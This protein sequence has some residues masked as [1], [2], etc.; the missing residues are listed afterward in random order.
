VEES[1]T[2]KGTELLKSIALLPEPIPLCLLRSEGGEPTTHTIPL[3]GDEA[4]ELLEPRLVLDLLLDPDLPKRFREL[5]VDM[6]QLVL[7][8]GRL[9]H[10]HSVQCGD[11]QSVNPRD[12]LLLSEAFGSLGGD[13]ANR[14]DEECR[15]AGDPRHCGP[16]PTES[17]LGSPLP[18]RSPSRLDRLS[19]QVTLQVVRQGLRRFVSPGRLLVQ[20]FQANRLQVSRYSGHQTRRADR[21][22]VDDLADRLHRALA[23][24]RGAPGEHLV[25]N[26]AQRVDVGRRTDLSRVP[27]PLLGGHVA[28][29]AHDLA[30][31]GLPGVRVDPL[32]QAEVGDLGHA[33]CGVK[34]IT[35][36]EVAMDDPGLVGD[37]DRSRQD[38]H[39]FGRRVAGLEVARQ[40]LIEAAAVEQFQ[41]HERQAVRFA[42]VIDLED[43]G[44]PEPGHR[45]GLDPEPGE[46]VGPR[47]AAAADHLEGDQAF[48]PAVPRL[49]D[50]AHS[51]LA[52]PVENLVGSD[53]R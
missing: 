20:G 25:E 8:S 52:Q 15:D 23:L 47:L 36:L 24:E 18:D 13:G 29:R 19:K 3:L 42:D 48:E 17:P 34:D 26:R 28:G 33:V 6:L 7:G 35:G 10:L 43:V 14:G 12:A 40:A 22:V 32:G 9:G 31:L 16:R 4:E 11:L 44:M 51:A 46:V 41:G 1:V 27:S 49:V 30:A 39:Q 38:R 50:N 5:V 45:L 53:G 37:V 21:V 2:Q